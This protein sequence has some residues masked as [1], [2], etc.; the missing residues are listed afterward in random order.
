MET[1]AIRLFVATF[2][3]ALCIT[4]TAWWVMLEEKHSHER[5]IIARVPRGYRRVPRWSRVFRIVDAFLQPFHYLGHTTYVL[6]NEIFPKTCV[7]L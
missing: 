5:H 2:E 7:Q 3:N 6:P 4:H 1:W